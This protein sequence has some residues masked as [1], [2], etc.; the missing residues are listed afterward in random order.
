MP[1]TLATLSS[2]FSLCT[3]T[4][5]LLLRIDLLCSLYTLPSRHLPSF[6]QKSN[7]ASPRFLKS[8]KRSQVDSFLVF[9]VPRYRNNKTSVPTPACGHT[10]AAP[11][12]S[13]SS[14]HLCLILFDLRQ[15][16]LGLRRVE[17]GSEVSPGPLFIPPPSQTHPTDISCQTVQVD[18]PAIR[19]PPEVDAL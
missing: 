2:A 5:P 3:T 12:D 16:P 1:S 8:P 18:A 11:D 19:R 4:F 13:T 6:D 7:L 10:R 17:N 14:R 9:P 15:R